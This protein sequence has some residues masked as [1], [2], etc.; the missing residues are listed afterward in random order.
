MTVCL[1]SLGGMPPTGGFFAKFYIFKSAMDA[2][3]Q[4]LL[5]LT[6]IGVINSAI[7]IFYYL[8]IVT[9]MYFKD[10]RNEIG[11]TRAAGL[12]FVMAACPIAILE[13]GLFPNWWLTL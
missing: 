12:M 7:S 3:D 10:A 13:M 8:R 6:A 5:W 2:Q 4:Q 11:V 9:S 1:L